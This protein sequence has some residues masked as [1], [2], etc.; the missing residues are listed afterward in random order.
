[1]PKVARKSDAVILTPP[2]TS[3]LSLLARLAFDVLICAI[4][5]PLDLL[6]DDCVRL[7]DCVIVF[8]N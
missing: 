1:M 7:L 6:F 2:P 8:Q 4:F 3:G 5:I